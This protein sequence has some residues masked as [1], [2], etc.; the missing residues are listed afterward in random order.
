MRLVKHLKYAALSA[1]ALALAIASISPAQQKLSPTHA[2]V[3]GNSKPSVEWHGQFITPGL[4]REVKVKEGDR[5]QK[6]QPLILQ[7]DRIEQNLFQ[8]SD[9]EAKSTVRVD[10]YESE[11]KT[12][13]IQLDRTV[14]LAKSGTANPTEV[15]EKQLAVAEVIAQRDAAELDR[16]GYKLKAEGEAVKIDQMKLVSPING[17]VSSLKL[18]E[19]EAVNPQ[20]RDPAIVIVQNDPLWCEFQL[21]TE[22]SARLKVGDTLEIRHEIDGPDAW[23]AGKVTFINPVAVAGA[24]WQ[25]VRVELPNPKNRDSG[26]VVFVRL[27]DSVANP[28]VAN[29][30]TR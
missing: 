5:V 23:V 26:M 27:P 17:I 9:I 24:G 28:A 4:V 10:L 19:G 18:H 11:R 3:R 29:A 15:E 12:K 16:K 21:P 25:S 6:G 1:S 13:Q 30:P 22:Q 14:D 2:E 20:D 7:D 8:Q